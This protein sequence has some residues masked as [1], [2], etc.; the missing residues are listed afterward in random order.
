M[1]NALKKRDKIL[2]LDTGNLL[3]V[4]DK[5]NYEPKRKVTVNAM[6]MLGYDAIGLGINEIAADNDFL[7]KM[8]KTKSITMISGNISSTSGQFCIE[9]YM[10]KEIN[11][12][13]IAVT[14][15]MPL[16][17]VET[18][19]P[20]ADLKV[21]DPGEVLGPILKEM[22][23]KADFTVVLS[24]YTAN[25][26]QIMINALTGIDLAVCADKNP[27]RTPTPEEM[28]SGKP[29][30]L[31]FIN[32]GIEIGTVKLE[33]DLAGTR[34]SS[35]DRTLLT[36]AIRTDENVLA[37][38]EDYTAEVRYLEKERAKEKK[39]QKKF[40]TLKLSPQ[41]FIKQFKDKSEQ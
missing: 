10:V 32:R 26:T 3:R 35:M 9:P 20:N 25:Q 6:E 17:H 27:P 23:E 21:S 31:S 7:S 41:E 24:T 28:A 30:M 13:K 40:T 33:K 37:L 16:K 1:I 29:M 8:C 5:K 36:P 14:S 38:I 18:I 11:G 12:I 2:L 19:R 22:N 34:I 39:L 4:N 15:I